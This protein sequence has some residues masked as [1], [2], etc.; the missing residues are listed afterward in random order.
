MTTDELTLELRGGALYLDN[1]GKVIQKSDTQRSGGGESP[2]QRNADQ[3]QG[4]RDHAMSVYKS[5]RKDASAQFIADAR[6]LR[7]MTARA[8]KRFPSSYRYI[9]TNGLLEMAR[10]IVVNA[11]KGNAVYL[12]KDLP[13]GDFDLRHRYLKMAEVTADAYLE[14]ITFAFSLVDDGN[15]FF[16]NKAEYQK[17]FN[18]LTTQGNTVLKRLRKVIDSDK[19]R[20]RRYQKEK[21]EAT[22]KPPP[23]ATGGGQ[24]TPPPPP[25]PPNT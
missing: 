24:H 1:N 9:V 23:K 3:R 25:W 18:G 22:P 15:S 20:W 4:K 7:R 14:E 16:K 19:D 17:V 10:E 12:H 11:V 6:E 5:R 21:T 8:V 13:Q 2:R